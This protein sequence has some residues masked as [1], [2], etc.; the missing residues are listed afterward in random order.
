MRTSPNSRCQVTGTLPAS[1]PT[2]K[3]L[4]I[5][6]GLIDGSLKHFYEQY[7]RMIPAINV[8]KITEDPFH[9]YCGHVCILCPASKRSIWRRCVTYSTLQ[10][11]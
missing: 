3:L 5:A 9:M 10:G 1:Y 2:V 6:G 8:F 4:D 7:Y 11:S